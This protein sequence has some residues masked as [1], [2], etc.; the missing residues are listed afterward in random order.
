M[1]NFAAASVAPAT[2]STLICRKKY[3]PFGTCP[4]KSWA[5]SEPADDGDDNATWQRLQVSYRVVVV[6]LMADS[7]DSV[8]VQFTE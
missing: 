2:R 1:W 3:I 6:R 4:S 7:R 5:S 8:L